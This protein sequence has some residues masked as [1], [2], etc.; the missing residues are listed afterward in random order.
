MTSL[1]LLDFAPSRDSCRSA[2][3]KDVGMGILDIMNNGWEGEM[4][5]TH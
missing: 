5:Y 3:F 2:I 4:K 1:P